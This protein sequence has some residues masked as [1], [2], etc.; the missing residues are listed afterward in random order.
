MG[1]ATVDCFLGPTALSLD[2]AADELK[3]WITSS[4]ESEKKEM[5][6]GSEDIASKNSMKEIFSSESLYQEI[7][8]PS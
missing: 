6:W 4:S 3:I 1:Q 5:S 8:P 2:A 7:S